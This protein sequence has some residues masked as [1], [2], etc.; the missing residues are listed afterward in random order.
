[1]TG[2]LI[3]LLCLYSLAALFRSA[4]LIHG[5]Y[6]RSEKH[7]VGGDAFCLIVDLAFIF[8]TSYL[9]GK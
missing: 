1:M 9:L 2:F 5:E 3:A 7:T 6:P 8:W 4:H